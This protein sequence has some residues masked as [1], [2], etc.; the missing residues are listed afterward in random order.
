ML[1]YD[2]EVSKM[3]SSASCPNVHCS[4]SLK[5]TKRQNRMEDSIKQFL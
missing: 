2:Q 3:L 4:G 5:Q 1:D